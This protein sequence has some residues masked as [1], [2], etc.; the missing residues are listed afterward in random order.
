MHQ[1]L[2]IVVKC[3]QATVIRLLQGKYKMTL[4]F[5]NVYAGG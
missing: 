4:T 1:H 3:Q 2:Q 5:E